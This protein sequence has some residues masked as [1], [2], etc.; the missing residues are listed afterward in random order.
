LELARF[1]AGQEILKRLPVNLAG[2]AADCIELVQPLA[3]ERQVKIFGELGAAEIT[4][5]P[6][7]LSQ[8]VMNLLTNAIQYNQ[9]GG[10]VRMRLALEDKLAV[11]TISDT[12]QGIAPKDIPRVFERFYRADQS[13]T[14]AGNAGLGLSICKAIIEAHGGTIEVESDAGAGS[15]FVVR[16]PV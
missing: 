5:D 8:V 16:L 6:E 1:D 15:K 3:D 10:E 13:R 9:P 2:V 4:G 11:L 7:R 12:G 14:G